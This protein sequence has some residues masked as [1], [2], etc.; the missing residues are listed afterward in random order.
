LSNFY[1]YTPKAPYIQYTKKGKKRGLTTK[2]CYKSLN[3]KMVVGDGFEPSKHSAADLQSIKFEAKKP[4]RG[5]FWGPFVEFTWL[6][7]ILV[8]INLH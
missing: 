2:E 3:I 5:I 4:K 7:C 8:Y 6:F 1:V